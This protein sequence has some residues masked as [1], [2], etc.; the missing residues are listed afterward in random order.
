V[1]LAVS[2]FTANTTAI[3][4]STVLYTVPTTGYNRDLVFA[5]GSAAG[6]YFNTGSGAT[7][8]T[9]IASFLVPSGQS[10][11]LM[12]QAPAG[13]LIYAI[14]ALGATAATGT[15]SLGWASVVSVI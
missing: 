15:I 7:G 3:S 1:A 5:N 10:A 13:A 11:V 14:P 2:Y 12:G 6:C 4:T 8:A 9:T